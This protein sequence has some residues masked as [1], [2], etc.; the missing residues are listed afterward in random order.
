MDSSIWSGELRPV[1]LQVRSPNQQHCL[2]GNLVEM[3]ILGCHLRSTTSETL[4]RTPVLDIL[5]EH[6]VILMLATLGSCLLV[7]GKSE[8]DYHFSFFFF[9]T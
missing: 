8:E 1:V 7:Y 6:P 4:G 3:Q 5:T 9:R 2:P